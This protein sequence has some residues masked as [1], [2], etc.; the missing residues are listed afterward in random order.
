LNAARRPAARALAVLVAG[1]L[2]ACGGGAEDGELVPLPLGGEIGLDTAGG[3]AF[4]LADHPDDVKL[5][6]FGYTTCPDVCPMTLARVASVRRALGREGDRV[7]AVL[8]SIDPERDTPEKLDQFLSFFG[9]R[10]VGV[11]GPKERLDPVVEAYHAFYSRVDSG[12]A[13]GYLMDHSTYIFLL[14][15]RDRVRRLIRSDDSVQRIAGWIRTLLAER[16]A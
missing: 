16:D 7:L 10:G 6:F 9:V 11:T 5:V 2:G 4:R 14:D 1:A 8:V 15:R 12:S 3:R 13:A